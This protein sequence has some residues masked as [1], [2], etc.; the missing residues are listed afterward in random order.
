MAR[1]TVPDHLVSPADFE[2][3]ST[4]RRRRRARLD[5]L[6]RHGV[7]AA[8]D[9]LALQRAQLALLVAAHTDGMV[10]ARAADAAGRVTAARSRLAWSVAGR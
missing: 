5:M 4:R 6:D 2:G 10:S 8:R 9:L 1:D 3:L 7:Q